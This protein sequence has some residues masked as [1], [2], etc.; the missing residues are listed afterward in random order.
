MDD[1]LA[2]AATKDS[3]HDPIDIKFVVN[4]TRL[5]GATRFIVHSILAR[6][7]SVLF[8]D[9]TVGFGSLG[10]PSSSLQRN[11]GGGAPNNSSVNSEGVIR[12]ASCTRVDMSLRLEGR[13]FAIVEMKKPSF[14]RRTPQHNIPDLVVSYKHKDDIY[15]D[16][17]RS[18]VLAQG[19]DQLLSYM[20]TYRVGYGIISSTNLW[21]FVWYESDTLHDVLHI[22]T[23]VE[24]Q[25]KKFVAV[26]SYFLDKAA[27]VYAV[28]EGKRPAYDF[29]IIFVFALKLCFVIC[30]P[31]FF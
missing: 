12:L 29:L 2:D 31:D 26:L 21:Y 9:F 30:S 11:M 3:Y 20:V 4:S 19:I 7:G 27:K 28:K 8:A 5:Y 18:L 6:V 14:F 25:D 10:E 24:W 17:N 13:D 1:Y 15:N 23:G 16:G 22:S